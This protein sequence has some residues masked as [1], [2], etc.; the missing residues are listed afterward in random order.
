MRGIPLALVISHC[1][2]G[3]TGWGLAQL[4]VSR[5]GVQ[6]A[7]SHERVAAM[8]Q[9]QAVALS[10]QFGSREQALALLHM[11][12]GHAAPVTDQPDERM[13]NSLREAA[14]QADAG[15]AQE[16]E[17]LTR[18]AESPCR[19]SRD[20]DCREAVLDEHRAALVSLRKS[21]GL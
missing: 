12:P 6:Q 7:P 4:I 17:R 10:F 14:L 19:R 3:A 13:L 20:R 21:S 2:C 5:M 15:Q 16:S 1:I 11:A 9:R 8:I 18:A